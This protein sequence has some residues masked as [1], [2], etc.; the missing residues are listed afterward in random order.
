MSSSLAAQICRIVPPDKL[1]D[2]LLVTQILQQHEGLALHDQV[3]VL[4]L[5]EVTKPWFPNSLL[6]PTLE[7]T[8]A[9]S[10]PSLQ[11]GPE[12]SGQ[13]EST[14]RRLTKL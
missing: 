10:L 7:K 14:L 5:F 6:L 8:L 13:F 3:V 1:T 4:Y 12:L 2:R 9:E 11:P